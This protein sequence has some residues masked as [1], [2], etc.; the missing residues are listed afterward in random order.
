[1]QEFHS[2]LCSIEIVHASTPYYID[3]KIIDLMIEK[4]GWYIDDVVI[5]DEKASLKPPANVTILDNRGVVKLAWDY[6]SKNNRN[7]KITLKAASSSE[8]IT[9]GKKNEV[10]KTKHNIKRMNPLNNLYFKIYKSSND[11]FKLSQDKYG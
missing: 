3:Y 2:T 5:A 6:L 4:S 10:Q 11:G 7:E 8:G 1:M 9:W